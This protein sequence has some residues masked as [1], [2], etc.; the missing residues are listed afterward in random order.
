MPLSVHYINSSLSFKLCNMTYT[1]TLSLWSFH[2]EITSFVQ[3]QLCTS[4]SPLLSRVPFNKEPVQHKRQH[5]H[6][7]QIEPVIDLRRLDAA[8][9]HLLHVGALSSRTN[10]PKHIIVSKILISSKSTLKVV[11]HLIALLYSF[12]STI[13]CFFKYFEYK[14][15]EWIQMFYF[16]HF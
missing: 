3:Q 9:T 15:S 4:V 10:L 1:W 16:N 2:T 7:S 11:F 6:K 8:L 5:G 12:K 14:K 13:Q